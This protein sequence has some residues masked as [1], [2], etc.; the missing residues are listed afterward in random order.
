MRHR[1]NNNNNRNV[2]FCY[3]PHIHIVHFFILNPVFWHSNT[4]ERFWYFFT[5]L[6]LLFVSPLF[7]SSYLLF[8]CNAFFLA[9]FWIRL[10]VCVWIVI[11][12]N[13]CF[14]A[15]ISCFI[16]D[17][18]LHLTLTNNMPLWCRCSL[19]IPPKS[20]TKLNSTK[21]KVKMIMPEPPNPFIWTKNRKNRTKWKI[22][23]SK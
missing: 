3:F 8:W 13:G 4:Y 12:L 6:L 15:V 22:E 19:T 7:Q 21:I 1:Q 17:K 16:T 5:R 11:C 2:A 23:T 20:T 10:C 14:N 9:H 18:I